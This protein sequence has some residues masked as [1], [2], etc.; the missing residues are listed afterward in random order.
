MDSCQTA[1]LQPPGSE[2][3][4]S[5]GPNKDGWTLDQHFA[6]YGLKSDARI[7]HWFDFE[8]EVV[9]WAR[10]RA[11]M[12]H[13][14]VARWRRARHPEL[15]V[16]AEE[17]N[18]RS[19]QPPALDKGTVAA[20]RSW[21][22]AAAARRARARSSRTDDP[23][24]EQLEEAREEEEAAIAPPLWRIIVLPRTGTI[25]ASLAGRRSGR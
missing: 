3:A 13:L 11:L 20:A 19:P 6:E 21:A 5:V 8:Q 24:E 7:A 23:D 16:H 17:E 14:A 10:D 2:G 12:P 18:F 25:G 1:A 22:S 4:L 15:E 9:E